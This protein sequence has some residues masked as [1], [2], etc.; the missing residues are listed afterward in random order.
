MDD[1]FGH[2][3]GIQDEDYPTIGV[4]LPGTSSDPPSFVGS[5]HTRDIQG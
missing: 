1:R 5:G 4:K 2:Y 3:P